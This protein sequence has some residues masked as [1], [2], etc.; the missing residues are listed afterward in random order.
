ME[1]TAGGYFSEFTP[2]AQREFGLPVTVPPSE[3]T[4]NRANRRES[5][6]DWQNQLT[7]E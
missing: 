4:A 7:A 6:G 5:R 1:S 2:R 3:V